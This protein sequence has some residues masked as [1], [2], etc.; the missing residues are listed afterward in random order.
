MAELTSEP[1]QPNRPSRFQRV[2]Q[3]LDAAAAGS[4]ATYQG[5]GPFWKLPLAEFL[6]VRL[7]GIPMIAPAAGATPDRR[8]APLT[9]A[10]PASG[11]SC[12]GGGPTTAAARPPATGVKAPGRGAASGLVRGIKGEYPFDGSQ[13]PR[14][15]WGGVAVSA[16][17]TA[18][19]ETWIDDGC[20]DE[21]ESGAP[22]QPPEKSFAL[23]RGEAAHP[24]A[25]S[26]HV[27][28]FHEEQGTPKIRKNVDHLTPDELE[29]LRNA[30]RV[31]R[32]YDAY[33][34]DERSFG[35]W[36]RIHAN[37]CQHG[38][39]E[40]LTWH[41]AYL[42][43]FEQ[44][45]QDVDPTV[46]LPYWDWTAYD[47]DWK[48]GTADSGVIPEAFR[49]WVDD[50]ALS[51]LSGRIP[52]DYLTGLKGIVG[53]KY[54]SGAR[55]FTAA[56]IKY[57]ANPPADAAINAALL[58][59]NQLWH[60]YRWPGPSNSTTAG[61]LFF[62]AYPTPDD[63]QRILQQPNF[64]TFGSGPSANH[65]Y[66]AL[67]NIHNLMH[68]FSGGVNPNYTPGGT[69]PQVGDMVQSGLTAFD[70]I[71]WAHH[72][73]VDR[74]WSE[75]QVLHTGADPD[76]PTA[77]LPPFAMNVAQT[78]N[79]A[80]L[81]YEYAQA[82]HL[83]PTS[84][85]VG[86]TKFQSAAAGVPN[87]AATRLRSVAGSAPSR[88]VPNFRRAEVRVHGVRLSVQ[89]GG[90]VRAFL[91]QPDATVA[92]PGAGND[93]FV[94]QANLFSGFCVGGPG[95]CEPPAG[96]KRKFDL[97]PRHHKTPVNLRIDATAA[98]NR[99]IAQGATDLAVTLVVVGADGKPNDHL[100]RMDGV[101]LV[102]LD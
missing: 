65:F 82:T 44:Q 61:T 76:N 36:A 67:E 13:F 56:G 17:D 90:A 102:F 41:R 19:I 57:G 79:I 86:F 37:L 95:H 25:P 22:A 51:G 73:N 35:Y 14:L 58:A 59:V 64:F 70:P 88:T 33:P 92:T 9:M 60:P 100:L 80:T 87:K 91:N 49:C 21:P 31:M 43:F 38:W 81:G 39:E 54:D 74:L 40:F 63:V 71:F 84:P 48:V 11:G 23:V 24:P 94:G 45:L 97:R 52:N 32:S 78:L 89:A 55:L 18:T 53:K 68:N 28:A 34:Q 83:F 99:L 46:T 1:P 15:P 98:A 77:I 85:A 4:K 2:Q 69:D 10:L 30:I 93:H 66:G 47:Q 5:Y 50:D 96:P 3:I 75:W 62:E 12:C 42:Y 101:S 20:P 26:H 6:N 72:S 16:A 7:Y 8:T 27:N 29:R